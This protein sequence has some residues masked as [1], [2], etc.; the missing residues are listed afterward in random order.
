MPANLVNV[1]DLDNYIKDVVYRGQNMEIF[2][3]GNFNSVDFVQQHKDEI[4]HS[5]LYQWAN[6]TLKPYMSTKTPQTMRFLPLI[7]VMDGDLPTWARNCMDKGE[8]VYRFKA[9]RIPDSLKNDITMSRDFLYSV[10]E[11]YINKIIARAKDTQKKY[12]KNPQAKGNKNQE[13][14]RIRMDYLKTSD[15]YNSFKKVLQQAQKW[16]ENIA[17]GSKFKKYDAELYKE[18][19]EGT[20]PEMDLADGMYVVR[21]TTPEALDFE[22]EYMGH[23]V[24]KGM[25]DKGVKDGSIKIYSLRDENG[26]PHATFEVHGNLIEQCKGKQDK[27]PVA[28]Y[29]PY[30]QE[31]VRTK[32]FDIG[33][34]MQNI[35]L[36]KHNRKYYDLFNLPKGKKMVLN[37]DLDVSG[38]ELTELPDFSSLIVKGNFFC[39]NN[40]LRSLH[41]SPQQVLCNF[42][43]GYNQLISLEGA[44][45]RVGAFYCCYNELTDLSGSPEYVEACYDCSNNKLESLRG[46]TPKLHQ[47]HLSG[48][49]IKSFADLPEI[50]KDLMAYNT[51][52][53][54]IDDLPQNVKYD[55]QASNP[56]KHLFVVKQKGEY[57][58][59]LEQPDGFVFEGGIYLDGLDLTELPDL[60]HIK[61][62]ED[63]CCGAN[64]LTSFK[65]APKEVGDE[66]SGAQ[67]PVTSLEGMPQ[68]LGGCLELFGCSKLKSL[69]G[70][71]SEIGDSI[72]LY[73]CDALTE[74]DVLPQK[75]D[76]E[77]MMTETLQKKYG[78]TGHASLPE[79]KQAITKHKM[80]EE[81]ST[82]ER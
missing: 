15:E 6:Y 42:D 20:K 9:D 71:A 82:R 60:S 32:K 28:K 37:G 12:E 58:N 80:L 27:A 26:E 44:P 36:I 1:K 69:K 49:P 33:G 68:K 57:C 34:D 51:A 43:C 77:I 21:L 8:P 48:N 7:N 40:K 55:V 31:F 22:S 75:L 45:Q 14:P 53:E 3:D 59:L 19:L 79:L 41:G 39:N 16:H 65:G 38:M 50:H 56:D 4:V 46:I 13:K 66:F 62:T 72:N 54:S 47:L 64:K 81:K 18:S 74:I 2:T 25:Y 78:T 67:N 10:G 35:G 70:I 73:N 63:F 11:A 24:G 30:V 29:R 61:V 17:T 5:M 52:I 76:G 23:C